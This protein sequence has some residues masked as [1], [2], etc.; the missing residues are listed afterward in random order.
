LEDEAI[1]KTYPYRYGG[2]LEEG[3]DYG[4]ILLSAYPIV[5]R[6]VPATGTAFRGLPRVVWARLD[7]GEGRTLAVVAAHLFPPGAET[8]PCTRPMSLCYDASVRDA[9]VAELR[10]FVTPLLREE[11]RLI[12]LGDF[13]VTEREPAYSDLSSGLLDSHRLAGS[14]FGYTWRPA[15]LIN[16]DL[17]LLRIDYI[18]SSPNVTPL[19]ASTD[20]TPRGS[21]HCIVYATFQLR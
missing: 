4:T 9:Q 10:A 16:R 21:D 5:E 6:G 18:F 11:E 8:P 14:G 1:A 12:M 2:Y 20:C 3:G 19:H 17:P 15:R 7:V 13:N